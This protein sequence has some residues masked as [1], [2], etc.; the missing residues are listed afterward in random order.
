MHFSLKTF[1]FGGLRFSSE[2]FEARSGIESRRHN[3]DDAK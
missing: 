1:E 2:H 3:L